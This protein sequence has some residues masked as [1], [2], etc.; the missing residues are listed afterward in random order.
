MKNDKFVLTGRAAIAL[1][2]FVVFASCGNGSGG[3]GSD[4]KA[5][6]ALLKK[7]NGTNTVVE[8]ALST[9]TPAVLAE[10]TS[11]SGSPGGDFSY[12]LNKAEDGVQIKKYT[13][14]S[15]VVIIPSK[16]EDYPVVSIN[17][18]SFTGGYEWELL[19]Y[20]RSQAMI[21]GWDLSGFVEP[22]G[23]A[24]MTTVVIPS[25]TTFIGYSAF[26]NCKKLHTVILPDTLEVIDSNAFDGAEE[27]YNLVIPE[28]LTSLEFGEGH[29]FRI[30]TEDAFAG[31]SKLPI[32][33]RKRLQELGYK[34]A[35]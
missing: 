35:F 19:P 32:K 31:C 9:V 29:P 25:G 4:A 1:L 21:L 23:G 5:A 15:A 27:L 24:G 26:R 14:K 11:T 12:G 33:T 30:E 16:I 3:A 6:A 13:G 34:G 18:D 20:I 2:F 8:K 28:T 7:L 17:G 10:L 22:T